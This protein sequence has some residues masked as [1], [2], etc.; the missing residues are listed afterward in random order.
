MPLSFDH[1]ATKYS[2]ANALAL[3]NCAKWAYLNEAEIKQKVSSELG[4]TKFRFI[5]IDISD[6]EVF[7]AGD[8]KKIII[9]FRGTEPTKLQDVLTD[10]KFTLVYGPLGKVHA[11]F[12]QALNS[13]W[14]E[15]ALSIRQFQD[16]NQTLW[17]TGHSLG[18]A[19]ATLA[20]AK[21][22][23]FAYPVAGLYTFGQ[24]RVGDQRF[25]ET[26]NKEMGGRYIRFVNNNDAVPRVPLRTMGYNHGGVF[27]YF[28]KSL[29]LSNDTTI[30]TRLL[31]G[32]KG[33]MEALGEKGT[34]GVNDHNMDTYVAG[35][36]KNISKTFG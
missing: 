3:S 35:V 34:D 14:R 30:W 5:H 16:N 25:V 32:V 6:T 27:M 29:N 1:L 21:M 36:A 2:P 22:V 8:D 4:L 19:L 11:G 28:D 20:V 13:A 10:A 23:E 18:A 26:I 7:V 31:D 33:R 9:S 17:F 12:I 15:V 24:P